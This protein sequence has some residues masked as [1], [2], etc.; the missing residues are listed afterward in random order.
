[1]QTPQKVPQ[2]SNMQFKQFRSFVCEAVTGEEFISQSQFFNHSIVETKNGIFIDGQCTEFS[3][4][5]EA[6]DHINQQIIKENIQQELYEEMSDTT[7][8]DIIR[9]HHSSVKV[10]NTLIESYV[11]LASSKFF[12]LDPV[13][14]DIRL[15]NKIDKIVE[16]C[17]DYKLDDGSVVVISEGT[18]RQLNNIFK[19]HQDVVQYMRESKD[20]F[21]E[22]LN[23][24]EE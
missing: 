6:R 13:S 2:K 17:V 19:E 22:V 11:E 4:V 12:T 15:L 5:E 8:A 10:T 23:L 7:I 1:M 3:C 16:G 24:L 18:Q 20:N 14:L 21:L 9:S